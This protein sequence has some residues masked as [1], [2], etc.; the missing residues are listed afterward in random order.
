MIIFTASN[1][2]EL[3]V[4]VQQPSG[5][6]VGELPDSPRFFLPIGT[7]PTGFVLDLS[8][9][10]QYTDSKREKTRNEEA[11]LWS[12]ASDG[13]VV[14]WRIIHWGYPEYRGMIKPDAKDFTPIKEEIST[15]P[16]SARNTSSSLS[17]GSKPEI[18]AEVK[19]EVKSEVKPAAVIPIAST[20]GD[21]EAVK[22]IDEQ[23]RSVTKKVRTSEPE[24]ANE[25]TV[26][27]LKLKLRDFSKLMA[28]TKTGSFSTLD[29]NGEEL[30]ST[31]QSVSA[32][33]KQTQVQHRICNDITVAITER[34]VR[35][36]LF[37]Y[38]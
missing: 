16:I 19:P 6:T 33:S 25:V 17:T 3:A 23:V 5:F 36:K 22:L 35:S 20:A 37:S 11:F 27:Q 29:K 13:N 2:T 10:G 14:D 28:D 1:A 12:M 15:V 24:L 32:V 30:S 31:L 4:I 9:T 34:N 8:R 26:S 38:I 18:K 21:A 7:Y